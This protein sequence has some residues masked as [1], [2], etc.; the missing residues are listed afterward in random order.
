MAK[1]PERDLLILI[2]DAAWMI[3]TRADQRAALNSRIVKGLNR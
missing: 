3:R 1:P 2:S